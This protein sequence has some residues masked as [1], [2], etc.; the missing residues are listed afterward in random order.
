MMKVRRWQGPM[1]D[2]TKAD[3]KARKDADAEKAMADYR[4]AQAA[5][6]ANT[7]RLRKLRLAREAEAKPADAPAKKKSRGKQRSGA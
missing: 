2:E 3:K 5:T 1:S 4:A 6:D 7:E